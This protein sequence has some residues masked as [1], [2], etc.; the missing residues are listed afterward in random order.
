MQHH[1]PIAA[2][3]RLHREFGE[4]GGVNVSIEPSTTFTVLDPATMPAI[5][6]G[7][8][9]HDAGGCYLYGRHF[10]PTVVSL[11]KQLAALEGGEAG[12]ATASGMSA[13]ACTLLQYCD[14]GDHVVASDTLYG[15]TYALLE[16]FLPRKAGL[17]T[18]FVNTSDLAAVEAAMT[19]GTKVLYVE[20]MS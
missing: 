9:G 19:P 4:H 11:G 1:D 15:G 17:R 12:Y 2:L 18:D 16:T 8:I 14:V 10:N 13:I 3:A 20:A 5:F 7:Q 6:Q